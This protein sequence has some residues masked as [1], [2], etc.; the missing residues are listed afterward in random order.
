MFWVLSGPIKSWNISLKNNK[1][2]VRNNDNLKYYWD[3]LSEDDFLF[4]YVTYPISGI[5][6]FGKFKI[7]Y[8]Q[9]RKLWDN[10]KIG[11]SNFPLRFD[12]DIIYIL[13]KDK[14]NK[15]KISLLG[16]RINYRKGLNYCKNKEAINKL[17]NTIKIRWNFEYK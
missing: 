7:K 13:P 6:G 8:V 10:K 14:W 2:G 16:T 9:Y 15:E 5:I 1:W 11:V 4:F 17:F 3:K 12:F